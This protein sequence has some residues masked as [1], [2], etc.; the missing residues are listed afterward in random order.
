M[1][2]VMYSNNY[3]IVQSPGYLVVT[4]EILHEARVIPLDGRAHVGPA[5]RAHMGD[6]RGRW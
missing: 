4:Y 2:P 3:Q 1:I 5:I 6:P